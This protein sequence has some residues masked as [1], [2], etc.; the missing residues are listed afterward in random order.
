MANYRIL[1]YPHFRPNLRWLKAILLLVDQVIRIVPH[2]ADPEDSDQL[3]E[4]IEEVPGCLTSISPRDFDIDIDD[5]NLR[6]MNKALCHIAESLPKARNREVDLSIGTEGQ[7]SIAGHV[8]LHRSKVS[9]PIRNALIEN[10]L[11]N[12][13][14]QGLIKSVGIEEYYSV[15]EQA[16]N[17]I[18]SYIA[19]RIAR[20]TGL[21]SVTDENLSFTVNA[22]D[23]TG[24]WLERPTGAI[25]G[26]LLN[27]IVSVNIPLIIERIPLRDYRELRNSYIDIRETFK[28]YVAHVSLIHRLYRIEDIRTLEDRLQDIAKKVR[29]ECDRYQRT[30]LAKQFKDWGPLAVCSLLTITAAIMDP[31]YAIAFASGTVAMELVKKVFLEERSTEKPHRACQML[32]DLRKEILDISSIQAL[33]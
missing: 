27:T 25:E 30:T 16:S 10:H 11:L 2:D 28:E 12:P 23:N 8:F 5:L 26:S 17:L 29:E 13:Q 33:I 22:L 3:K 31:A 14:L 32:A 21:D 24:V 6:R 20:R 1:Y 18:L 19:D 9:D 15:P 4:L 7:I